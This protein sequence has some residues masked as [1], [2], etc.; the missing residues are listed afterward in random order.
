MSPK[1][2]IPPLSIPKIV[3]RSLSIVNR[4][5]RVLVALSAISFSALRIFDIAS[6]GLILP[7]VGVL[8]GNRNT[9][10]QFF[11]ERFTEYLAQFSN[12]QIAIGMAIGLFV[13]ILI[14]GILS[15][16]ATYWFSKAFF[17]DESR[18][19]A[20][21]FEAYLHAPINFHADNN[22]ALLLRNLLSS[23]PGWYGRVIRPL[24]G[25]FSDIFLGIS[26]AGL[27]IYTNAVAAM[28]GLGILL[29]GSVGYWLVVSGPV[30]TLA[31][32]AHIISRTYNQTV[33]ESL[34]AISD[35]KVLNK[36]GYFSSKF[37]KITKKNAQIAYQQE[38]IQQ[39]PQNLLE[40]TATASI[41]GFILFAS[42]GM[43]KGDIVAFIALFTASIIR[44][45]PTAQRL[46]VSL[47]KFRSA[48][49]SFEQMLQ[50]VSLFGDYFLNGKNI[51]EFFQTEA[52]STTG[53]IRHGCDIEFRNINFQY[54]QNPSL[55]NINIKIPFG[56][57]IGVVG[58]SGS[59]KTTL[60][61]ILLGLLEPQSG[62]ILFD[63]D[64]RP[65]LEPAINRS[66][67][68]VPQDI[69]LLDSSLQQNIAFGIENDQIDK[70]MI[71]KTIEQAQL[72]EFTSSLPQGFD[73]IFGEHGARLS[74][75]QRQRI[76]ISRA[77][78]HNPNVLVLDEATSA[79]DV[80]TESKI[81]NTLENLSEEKTIVIIAHRLST[82]QQCDKLIFLKDGAI[83]AEGSFEELRDTC[84]EFRNWINKAEPIPGAKLTQV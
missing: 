68:Y 37:N 16:A 13:L 59:G 5:T 67:G 45:M 65:A 39:I 83:L 41:V 63:D 58:P 62:E 7:I 26:I 73:T 28:I 21:L 36:F 61:R 44:L 49:P 70:E 80:E 46:V 81:S 57:K 33:L 11:G 34:G 72:T 79:L 14:K 4:R 84:E 43:I 22:S 71:K 8:S 10:T 48:V 50:D 24:G 32:E 47:N 30:R 18:C 40:I 1:P 76:A 64:L 74:G 56:S 66:I 52:P 38:V 55:S 42:A 53:A 6:L 69:S 78:Y 60:A 31:R 12:D 20:R 51:P 77:L 27:L 2:E 82:V 9:V 25:I 17:E 75:G 35:I 15:I 54:G 3:S 23:V 29:I 19:A